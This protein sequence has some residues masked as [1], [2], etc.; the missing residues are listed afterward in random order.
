[1][2]SRPLDS[3]SQVRNNRLQ[4]RRICQS[5]IGAEVTN[6]SRII[7]S[8]RAVKGQDGVSHGLLAW[9]HLED[10]QKGLREIV[11]GA[12]L[13]LRFV[14]IKLATKQLHPKQG[15][16]DDEEKKQKQQRSDG[17]HGV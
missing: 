6:P 9:A 2:K 5:I 13:G 10:C 17:L 11:K 7:L 12:P 1:M 4:W 16:D 15:K 3:W 8:S 14:K